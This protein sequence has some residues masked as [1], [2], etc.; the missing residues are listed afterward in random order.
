MNYLNNVSVVATRYNIS[1]MAPY[2][3]VYSGVDGAPPNSYL[4]SFRGIQA[5]L[6]KEFPRLLFKPAGIYVLLP[7]L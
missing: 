1:W 6:V 7:R 5:H 3:K 2:R 4:N